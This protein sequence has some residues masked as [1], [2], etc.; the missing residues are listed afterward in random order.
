M[1]TMSHTVRMKSRY[2]CA[3]LSVLFLF[4]QSCSEHFDRG[5]FAAANSAARQVKGSIATGDYSLFAERLQKFA[6]E[7]DA[8]K[9]KTSSR[10]EGE[11][12]D[13]YAFLHSIYRDGLLLWKYRTEFTRYGFVPE[14]LI[15]VGQDIEPIVERYKLNTESHVYGPTMQRWKSIPADSIRFVWASADSQLEKIDFLLNE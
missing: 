4:F 14:G 1:N 12:L 5:K 9:G 3:V 8:L 6:H 13:A 15:Y 2:I 7:I 11:L 10:R